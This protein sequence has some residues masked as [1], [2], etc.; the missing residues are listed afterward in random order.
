MFDAEHVQEGQLRIARRFQRRV[1]W[2]KCRVPSGTTEISVV[3]PALGRRGSGPALKRRPIGMRSLR[4]Q[5]PLDSE[6]HSKQICQGNPQQKEFAWKYLPRR[7]APRK[8]P[9]E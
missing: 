5:N 8:F 3:P 4:G 2:R 9:S 6:S 7:T 1:C